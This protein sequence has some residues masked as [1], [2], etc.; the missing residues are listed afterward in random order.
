MPTLYCVLVRLSKGAMI[1]LINKPWAGTRLIFRKSS[2]LNPTYTDRRLLVMMR[3]ITDAFRGPISHR[4]SNSFVNCWSGR[5]IWRKTMMPRP[6]VIGAFLGLNCWPRSTLQLGSDVLSKR[7]ERVSRLSIYPMMIRRLFF[8][9]IPSV[10][11]H[12]RFCVSGTYFRMSRR[13]HN[14][15]SCPMF[16]PTSVSRCRESDLRHRLQVYPVGLSYPNKKKLWILCGT[17]LKLNGSLA[18]HEPIHANGL[19]VIIDGNTLEEKSPQ[20]L[21]RLNQKFMKLLR[22]RS[23]GST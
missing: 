20:E 13:F 1:C 8:F 6:K 14:L 22:T 23:N 21:W 16:L 11:F 4:L 3:C 15:P 5:R 18:L 7:V 19:D 2:I 12:Y 17:I 9:L 10:P